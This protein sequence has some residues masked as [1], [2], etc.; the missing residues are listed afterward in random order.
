MTADLASEVTR[1]T[2][3]EGVLT[4]DLATEVAARKAGS[5]IPVLES[6]VVAGNN[7]MLTSAPQQGV[8][9]IL[10]FATVRY[11][12]G[13]GLA[14]DAPVTAGSSDKEFIVSV[15]SSNQWDGFSV[16]VQYVKA[17]V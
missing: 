17:A 10:N 11:I 4:A 6:V 15:D 5:S 8:N 2:A 12:D 9:G 16:F 3:A 14:Y 7:I 1:A 13:N